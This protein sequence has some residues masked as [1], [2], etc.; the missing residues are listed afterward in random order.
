M[1]DRDKLET[2]FKSRGYSDYR[3]IPSSEIVVA[4]WV[5]MKCLFG[6]PAYGRNASCPPNALSVA[7][8]QRFFDEYSIAALFHFEKAV[9]QPEDRH[10]WSRRVNAGLLKLEREVFLAGYRKALLLNMDSCQICDECTSDRGDC[11][12]PKSARPTPE[13]MAIDV[14]STVRKVGYPIEVLSDYSQAM[15]RYAFMMV[16]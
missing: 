12:H 8:C 6:C 14:F 16:E 10:P 2:L 7:E 1:T 4:H 9:A 13:A 15:N 5:R 11:Q 3:W